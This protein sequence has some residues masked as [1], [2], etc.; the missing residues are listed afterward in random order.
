MRRHLTYLLKAI[1]KAS[2][3]TP[4]AVNQAWSEVLKKEYRRDLFWVHFY[5]AQT[6]G[7]ELM[8][9]A[10]LHCVPQLILNALK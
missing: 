9:K 1:A 7:W 6:T 2:M 8:R 5:F 10:I 3:I 4:Q